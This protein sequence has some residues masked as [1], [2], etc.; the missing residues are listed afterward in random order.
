VS[1]R[2]RI[3]V[4]D[5]GRGS[6]VAIIRSLGRRGA[7]VVAGDSEQ[8]SPGFRSRYAAERVVYPPPRRAPAAAAARILDAA[9]SL[10][11]DLVIPVTDD[12][13]LPLAGM[14]D[15]FDRV[16]AV[17]APGPEELDA[18]TDK[19]ATVEL[20]RRLGVPVPRTALADTVDGAL[21]AADELGW[22][23]VV[24]PRRSRRVNGAASM[25][26][27]EVA[28]A[29]GPARVAE[30]VSR[31]GGAV[32]VQEH[33]PGEGHG[34]ELLLRE[35]EPVAA[36]QHRRLR[37]VPFTGG[38]SSLRE[39]VPLDP[40]LLDHALRLLDALRWTG[41]AMVEFKLGPRG[42]ALMEV[43][44]R[45]WGSL[46][47]AAKSGVDFPALLAEL[48]LGRPLPVPAEANG[49]YRVGV[50][51]RNVPLE[52]AWVGSVLRRRRRYPFL[53]A[54]PRRRALAVA[55][56]LLDPRDGYDLLERDDPRPGLAELRRVALA[57]VRGRRRA[58]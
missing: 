34:V 7:Y 44:G 20:A 52:L 48:H 36:F 4:T 35:G 51:S 41:L 53:P 29:D 31:A 27:F 42:A 1:A 23:V 6:A 26:A 9:A 19:A 15:A 18:V 12:V 13:L 46:P 2:P 49:G 58:R 37:E 55:A 14:R 40:A 11:I 57:A 8:D 17:A 28:Y 22:P 47:L 33:W 45:V 50:R 32:L 43:N 38:A 21:A 25:A 56:R 30:A 16:C 39:S 54:P 5:A 3:L 10:G 24:K